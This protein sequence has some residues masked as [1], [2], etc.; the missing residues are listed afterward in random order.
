VTPLIVRFTMHQNWSRSP[1]GMAQI[2]SNW[3]SVTLRPQPSTSC[4]RLI[5]SVTSCPSARTRPATLSG[6][7]AYAAS[8]MPPSVMCSARIEMS[9]AT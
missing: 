2:D 1:Y 3:P 7:C 6:S 8:T 4:S 5:E 9:G